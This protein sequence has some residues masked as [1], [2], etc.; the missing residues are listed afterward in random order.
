MTSVQLTEYLQRFSRESIRAVCYGSKESVIADALVRLR[1]TIGTNSESFDKS[2]T[3]SGSGKKITK[4]HLHI[5]FVKIGL[6]D[7]LGETQ[8]F[9][10][11]ALDLV[12]EV[13]KIGNEV[14]IRE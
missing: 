9:A 14:M 12:D 2:T 7:P 6:L 8:V 3:I 11:N 4:Q 1:N 13:G 10:D 5:H